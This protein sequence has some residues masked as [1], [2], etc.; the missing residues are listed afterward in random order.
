MRLILRWAWPALL[1][2]AVLAPSTDASAASLMGRPLEKALWG[3]ARLD[4]VSQFPRYRK[5]GVTIHQRTMRWDS[6]APT[7]PADPT[8]PGDPAY[9]WPEETDFAVREAPRSGIDVLIAVLGTPGWANGDTGWSRPPANAQDYAD[10][11]TAVSRRYPSV[12]RW[13]VWVEPLRNMNFIGYPRD[14]DSRVR[15][16]RAYASVLDAAYVALK[17][18]S[19]A[20]L[21][22]GGNTFT[23]DRKPAY[24]A[25]VPLYEWMRELRLPNGRPPRMDLWGHNPFTVREP[26]FGARPGKPLGDVSDIRRVLAKLNR[27]VGKPLGRRVPVF[28]SEFCVPHGKNDLFPVDLTLRE[29][30]SWLRTAYALLRRERQV[31]GFG[32][33]VWQDVRPQPGEDRQLVTCGL[34]N[35]EGRP[36]PVHDLFGRLPRSRP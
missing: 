13:M 5:L 21:V 29:Q 22:I 4:G 19:K 6:V 11:M 24:W 7:R 30:L 35:T 27:Y 17:R 33:W 26:E 15:L 2:L 25:P 36:K 9:M 10:F 20:N 18:E 8:N 12:R 31:W 23:T 34:V 32:W 28:V 1:A 16:A 3:P 14:R